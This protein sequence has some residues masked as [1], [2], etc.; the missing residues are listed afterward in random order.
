MFS[1]ITSK[2]E[3]LWERRPDWPFAINWG[4]R[5]AQ[6][7]A[8]WAPMGVVD[9][10]G[11]EYDLV[12]RTVSSVTGTVTSKL[13]QTGCARLFAN[14]YLIWSILPVA[15]YPLTLSAWFNSSDTS[16]SQTPLGI[17][18]GSVYDRITLHL[19]SGNVAGYIETGGFFP[20][21]GSYN[22]NRDQHG[23]MAVNADGTGAVWRDAR[24]KATGSGATFSAGNNRVQIGNDPDTNND[25]IGY[26][27]DLRIYKYAKTDVEVFELFDPR[28]RNELFYPLRQKVF[29]FP[30]RTTAPARTAT[31]AATVGAA[32]ASVAATFAPGTKTAAVAATIGA[33]TAAVSAQAVQPTYAA[34]VAANVGAVTASVAATSGPPTFTAVV[35]ATVGPVTAAVA[36]AFTKPVYTASVT[37]TVGAVTAAASATSAQPVYTATVAAT[38]GGVTAAVVG[39]FIKPTYTATISAAVGGATCAVVATFAKPTYTAVVTAII[40]PVAAAVAA[41]FAKPVYAATIAATVGGATAAAQ[42][43]FSQPAYTALIQAMVGGVT[44]AVSATFTAPSGLFVEGASKVWRADRHRTDT[45]VRDRGWSWAAVHEKTDTKVT[46]H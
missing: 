26:T 33:V 28:T 25:L 14:G 9:A 42:A 8:F 21:S 13:V 23:C 5:Q 19:Y 22:A 16:N 11:N 31:V 12:S 38:T 27:W 7:L 39:T 46:S 6:G 36:A 34:T 17:T 40:G 2:T 32:T 18:G 24:D 29:S 35:S 43:L 41:T 1:I 20:Q 37:A 3:E 30:K 15:A 10:G 44:A 45:L 4:S